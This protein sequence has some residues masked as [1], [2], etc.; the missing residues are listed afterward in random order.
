MSVTLLQH[1]GALGPF[2]DVGDPDGAGGDVVH[3]NGQDGRA[4]ATR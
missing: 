3:K 1:F 2:G 4:R